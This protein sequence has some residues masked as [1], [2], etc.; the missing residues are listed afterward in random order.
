[1][2]PRLR[3]LDTLDTLAQYVLVSRLA[4][5]SLTLVVLAG[6]VTREL[7]LAFVFAVLLGLNSVALHRW[8]RWRAERRVELHPYYLVLDTT[9]SAVVL[10]VVGVGAPLVLYL[11]GTVVLAGL[12]YPRRATACTALMSLLTLEVAHGAG[13][14]YLPGG[15]D[16]HMLVTLPTLVVVAGFAGTSVRHLVTRTQQVTVELG[17]L[18]AEAAA[19]EERLRVARDLHDSVIKGL[20]GVRMLAAAAESAAARGD[21]DG[22][23]TAA[24]TAAGTAGDL[25]DR[26]RG[27]VCEL[28]GGAGSRPIGRALDEVVQEVVMGHGLR[29]EVRTGD[30]GPLDPAVQRAVLAIAG[31][32]LH[33]TV[34]HAAAAHVSV[35]LDEVDGRLRLVVEDDGRGFD[36]LLPPGHY[37]VVGMR[38]RAEH[39]GGVLTVRGG[40]GRGT[41]VELLLPH[42]VACREGLQGVVA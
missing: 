23:R 21:L 16:V 27:V 6:P 32:A 40:P 39:L 14:G 13:W 26:A 17:L 36:G 30:T 19:R 24:G 8:P 2:R 31:E 11:V 1:M 4:A 3:R 12:V 42:R 5:V 9:L 25:A 7:P 22:A 18:Q 33:N 35:R 34:R 10:A 29:V 20:Y 38:E 28:R 15:D 37:G 41:V